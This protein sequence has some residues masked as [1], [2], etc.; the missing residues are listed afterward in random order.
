MTAAANYRPDDQHEKLGPPPWDPLDERLALWERA[1]GHD[2]RMKCLAEYGCMVLEPAAYRQG[3]D[4]GWH[5]AMEMTRV[6]GDMC[7]QPTQ[8]D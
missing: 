1:H 5:D 8:R 7:R 6:L 3:Y 4:D 2:V